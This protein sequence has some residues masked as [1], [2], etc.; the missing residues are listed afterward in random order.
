MSEQITEEVWKRR[1]EQFSKLG[2]GLVLQGN[3]GDLFFCEH[4]LVFS[5]LSE[6]TRGILGKAGFN[7]ILKWDPVN[8]LGDTPKEVIRALEESS[9]ESKFSPG[10]GNAYDL[11]EG[12][13]EQV[14][15]PDSAD[16]STSSAS[17]YLDPR[18]FFQKVH[19]CVGFEKIE[20]W[21]FIIDLAD[22]LFESPNARSCED[23]E[24]SGLLTKVIEKLSRF[25]IGCTDGPSCDCVILICENSASL[26]TGLT[27]R[28]KALEEISIPLPDRILR[29]KFLEQNYDELNVSDMP[30]F[31][32]PDWQRI[33]ECLEGMSIVA[34]KKIVTLSRTLSEPIPYQKLINLFR[35]GDQKSP[36]EDLDRQKV[37]AIKESLAVRVK[38]QDFAIEKVSKV[39]QMAFVGLSGLQ[40][41]ARQDTPKGTLFFVGPTGV[42]KTE[43]AKALAEF[44][45]G[46]ESAYHRFDM[47]E[48]NHEQADQRLLGAPPGYVGY[49]NGGQLT[50]ALKE[51]PFTVLLF[52]EIEKAHP[53][54]LDKFLQILEDGRLTDGRGETVSFSESVIV[55][56]SNIGASRITPEVGGGSD[57][58]IREEFKQHVS[59]HFRKKL[60]RPELLNR[61]GNNIVPFNFIRDKSMRIEIAEAK[62]SGIKNAIKEKKGLDSLVFDNEKEWLEQLAQKMEK[63]PS[64]RAI[65]NAIGSDILDPLTDFL[66]EKGHDDHSLEGETLHAK[67]IGKESVFVFS[68]DQLP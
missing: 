41:S 39:V 19:D 28:A 59:D 64:G 40:H 33:L 26:P 66:I 11:D 17:E 25:P 67:W 63:E 34:I 29:G 24:R 57:E 1:L 37:T 2:G 20:K 52:D 3:V 18:N 68:T 47:S 9:L 42:G 38:G 5:D 58:E 14:E 27:K 65:T 48:Y 31:Q 44:L 56:T 61:L 22:Y 32:T 45:F 4:K 54:I 8:G 7:R 55:F 51:K 62:L 43:L 49:E 15:N 6:V 23:R 53:K 46:E 21:A 36:W 12:T 30:V 10:E 60:E 13:Q 35:Y 50:N 16:N